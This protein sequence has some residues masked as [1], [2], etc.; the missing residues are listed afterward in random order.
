MNFHQS[1]NFYKTFIKAP[2]LFGNILNLTK[3]SILEFDL[4]QNNYTCKK[5]SI[6]NENNKFNKIPNENIV[7]SKIQ[8][9][10]EKHLVADV[11]ISLMLSGGVDSSILAKVCKDIGANISTFTLATNKDKINPD[12]DYIYAKLVSKNLGLKNNFIYVNNLK[13]YEV[14]DVLKY[15]PYCDPAIINRNFIKRNKQKL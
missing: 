11:P 9:T 13:S 1:A 4:T 10:V 12:K 6:K 3:S 14:V 5:F 15:D 2:K 7:K 8:E